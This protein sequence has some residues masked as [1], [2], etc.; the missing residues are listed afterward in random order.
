[1]KGTCVRGVGT[2]GALQSA[3]GGAGLALPCAGHAKSDR[4]YQSSHATRR[5]VETASLLGWG[6]GNNETLNIR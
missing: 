3:P 1:M 5:G 6:R 4:W 2:A